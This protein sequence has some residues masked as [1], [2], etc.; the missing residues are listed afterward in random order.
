MHRVYEGAYFS[1][2]LNVSSYTGTQ[3]L[4]ALAADGVINE[5]A[6]SNQNL[7]NVYGPLIQQVG[8]SI[9]RQEGILNNVQVRLYNG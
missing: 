5:E 4:S 3:F 9:R 8:D 1:P 2:F 7:D 6:I